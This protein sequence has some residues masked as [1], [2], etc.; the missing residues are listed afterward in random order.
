[1]MM[2]IACAAILMGMLANCKP[3]I[4]GPAPYCAEVLCDGAY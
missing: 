4:P 1:M 2:K 3:I